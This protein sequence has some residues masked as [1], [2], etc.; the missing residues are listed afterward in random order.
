M[1]GKYTAYRALSTSCGL[2]ERQGKVL[3]RTRKAAQQAEPSPLLVQTFSAAAFS[4]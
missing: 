1:N 3:A 2:V 4:Q